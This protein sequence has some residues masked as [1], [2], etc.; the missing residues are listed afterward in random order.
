VTC[1]QP[2]D[3]VGLGIV[4][5]NTRVALKLS[6]DVDKV[7]DDI[8]KVKVISLSFD[9]SINGAF[10]IPHY[11]L[12]SLLTLSSNSPRPDVGIS[13]DENIVKSFT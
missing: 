9:F 13:M 11:T 12:N 7:I 8:D 2:S 4:I 1:D 3:S 5:I 6:L 10:Q